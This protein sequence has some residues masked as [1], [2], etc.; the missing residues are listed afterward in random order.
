MPLSFLTASRTGVPVPR[1]GP[2]LAGAAALT[3][4]AGYVNT[5]VLTYFAV[6][7][8]HVSGAVSRIGLD[9][10]GGRTADLATVSGIVA[11]FFVGAVLSG[12]AI[13]GSEV[14]V[15]RRYGVALVAEGALLAAAALFLGAGDARLGVV[16]AAVACGLQNGLASHYRGLVL[17]TT[18]MTGIVTDLGVLAG[19][20]L[21]GAEVSAWK[22]RFLATLL[23]GFL[24]GSMAGAWAVPQWGAG[25]LWGAA[26]VCGVL[27]TAYT[28]VRHRAQAAER[29]EGG[30][31]GRASRGTARALRT[32]ARRR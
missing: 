22:A 15:G 25:A 24:V 6:P 20:R 21:R 32:P 30:A 17:R 16:A 4:L 8:S 10:V 28:A 11:G 18:H 14:A 3:V 1:R 27:G 23:A 2:V 12:L 13:G 19:H 9:V 29:A 7:V 31:S 5:T 26:V